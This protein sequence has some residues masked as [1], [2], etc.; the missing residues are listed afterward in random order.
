MSEHST[1]IE[2]GEDWGSIERFE[3]HE[4]H[5][6]V[7][8][9]AAT[10]ALGGFLFG[11]DS[12]V[13]NGAVGAIGDYFDTPAGVLGFAVASA[14]I[15]AAIGAVMAGRVADR[16]GR[17]KAMWMA[18]ILFLISAIGSGLADVLWLLIAFRV[19]GGVGVGAASVIAP[20]Y[21]AEIAPAR[22]RGRLGSLQQLAI[23]TG[24]FIALLIDYVL[25][26]AAGGSEKELWLGLEAWR[27]MFLSMAIPSVL[28]GGLAL[29]IPESP[30]HLV[31]QG[32]ID[33]ARDVLRKVL[34]NIDLD[35]KIAQI[36]QTMTAKTRPSFSDLRGPFLGLLP[37]VWVGIG[38]SVFQQ[39]VGINVIF[40]YS[41]IL[42]QAVGFN[43]SDSLM[44]T[45]ITSVVNVVTT[46]IAIATIDRFGRKPLLLI[47]SGGM[48]IT[49]GVMAIVFGTADT[50]AQGEPV[51]HGL[52]GPTALVAANLFVFSFGM[53]WGP[54]V[55]VLLGETFPNRIRA[56]ALSV[57]AA[58]QWIANWIVSVSF[59]SLKNAGLGL[60]YG[61]YAGCAL[62]SLLF[63]LRFVRETKGQELEEMTDEVQIMA[64]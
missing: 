36:R 19:I 28:Y 52:A 39:F 12:A 9:C 13:I 49:L 57:A 22:I 24:I 1:P 4:S 47:G 45:V 7:T 34:G 20:A 6:M 54:V 50:N 10:A 11:Y 15:G 63:V 56:A 43:E 61:I 60:A 30:R 46:L 5:G 8:R 38:L 3:P 58:S 2:Q 53:S 42:W 40:Y 29:T 35:A 33:E 17:L 16:L 27:W 26:T 31:R 55:W 64:H 44:I 62:L 25:A 14:L 32:R 51:L 21:I 41:S 48:T 59:P 18:A 37:I 23:V